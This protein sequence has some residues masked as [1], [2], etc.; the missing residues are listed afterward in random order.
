MHFTLNMVGFRYVM[1]VTLSK[2]LE[3]VF[4]SRELFL[5]PIT[6]AKRLPLNQD[7]LWI[8]K[9]L[10]IRDLVILDFLVVAL[11]DTNWTVQMFD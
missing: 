11:Q 3:L 10:T 6:I 5:D 1:L 2:S 9:V 7:F 8:L 4:Q